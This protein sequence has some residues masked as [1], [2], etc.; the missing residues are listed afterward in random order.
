MTVFT[1]GR[2]QIQAYLKKSWQDYKNALSLL[3]C[4][5]AFPP[6]LSLFGENFFLFA[7]FSHFKM[8]YLIAAIILLTS[9]IL[10]KQKTSFVLAF[11]IIVLNVSTMMPFIFTPSS[12]G[13][14][15]ENSTTVL[16]ANVLSSNKNYGFLNPFLTHDAPDVILLL[17]F[18]EHWRQHVSYL[19]DSY[20]HQIL[21]P[22]TDNF[23]IAL[24]SKTP[25]SGAVEIY[26]SNGLSFPY[27]VAKLTQKEIT[28]IGLH[29]PPPID[30]M[31]ATMRN[32]NLKLISNITGN[33]P[34]DNFIV[35]G[36]YNDTLWSAHMR[37]FL[38]SSGLKPTSNGLK[39]TWPRFLSVF[40][41]QIDHAFIKNIDNYAFHVLPPIG[42]DHAPILL[43]V[44]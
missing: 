23:G 8:Q 9:A 39:A 32:E 43:K 17:E 28:L 41:I 36:D 12:K 3:C 29:P 27:I 4:L 44:Q 22:R 24:Y 35:V 38:T 33:T 2:T 16:S 40:G 20:P 15:D 11:L 25:L 42:S 31:H 30:A 34:A 6:I 21:A 37:Q 18:N 26:E 14:L 19:D 5:L 10:A 1:K 7:L 13:I